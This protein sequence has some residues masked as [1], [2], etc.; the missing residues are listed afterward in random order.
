MAGGSGHALPS[1]TRSIAV[2]EL[3]DGD[4]DR[5]AAVRAGWTT[6]SSSTRSAS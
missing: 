5:V 3:A 4:L 6:R 1:S 2:L